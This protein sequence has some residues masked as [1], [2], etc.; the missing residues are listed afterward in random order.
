VGR[1]DDALRIW[2]ES[3]EARGD[4]AAVAA[5]QTGYANGGYRGA[6][7]A[8]ADTLEAES[9]TRFVTPWQIGTLYTR[10]GDEERAL[11]Y[12]EKAYDAHDPNVPYLAIDPIFDFMRSNPR[13][14]ALVRKLGLPRPSAGIARG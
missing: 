8:A 2:R 9:K 10:A 7:R 11:D 6:L 1:Y 13:F 4:T 3:Y 12:L 5:L 14:Q